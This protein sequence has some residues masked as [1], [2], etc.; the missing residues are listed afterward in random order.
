MLL[1]APP[2]ETG[3]HQGSIELT[4]SERGGRTRLTQVR[5]RPPLQVQQAL[6]PD[7]GLPHLAMVMVS[8][9]TGGI[10]QGDHHCI[11]VN[12]EP[13]AVAH[14]TGQGATR[15]HSMPQGMARQD[16]NLV[17]AKGGY[18][19]Y[20]PDPLI[21]YRDS[22]F[23]QS[24]TLTVASG[25]N[26]IYWDI[27]TP[28]RVAMGESF[29]YRRLVSR[30]EVR[31]W[32][33]RPAYREAF[34]L[35]PSELLSLSQD[36]STGRREKGHGCT[37]GSMLVIAVGPKRQALLNDLQEFL[38]TIPRVS[39]GATLLPNQVGVGI[40]ALGNEATDVR[41]ALTRCWEAARRHLLGSGVPFLRKY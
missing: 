36:A 26:L 22:D 1:S 32:S 35:D 2:S 19:E 30:L 3:I 29:R 33:G 9:P 4:L 13:G 24:T 6:Y 12:V 11:G 27:L 37:L 41:N 16:M 7:P 8:N 28:G 18:L 31:D 25:G 34:G 17:V 14:V 5:S 38:P 40:R 15:I 10:F 39:A 20:L 23:E 21:P